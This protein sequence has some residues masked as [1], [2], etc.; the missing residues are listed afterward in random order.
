MA[1]LGQEVPGVVRAE[2]TAVAELVWWH[3]GS[4]VSWP[5]ALLIGPTTHQ[6]C[7]WREVAFL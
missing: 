5:F 1:G 4:Q 6:L 2:K 3:F 7:G